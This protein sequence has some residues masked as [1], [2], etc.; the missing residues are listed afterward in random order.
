MMRKD[1]GFPPAPVSRGEETE[2][3]IAPKLSAGVDTT[4]GPDLWLEPRMGSGNPPQT[5]CLCPAKGASASS[6]D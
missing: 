5:S 3:V 4:T 1:W 6:K 2:K